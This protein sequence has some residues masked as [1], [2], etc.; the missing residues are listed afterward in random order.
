[1]GDRSVGNRLDLLDL[2]DAQVG[3]PAVKSKQGVVVGTGVLGQA[4]TGAGTIEHPAYR[5]TIEA[6]GFNAEC[7]G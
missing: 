7:G 1:M 4:V 6:D 5:D 3:E 2:E